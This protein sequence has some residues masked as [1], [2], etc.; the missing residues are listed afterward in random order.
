MHRGYR[1]IRE[2]CKL[3]LK[4]SEEHVPGLF[5]GFVKEIADAGHLV[6]IVGVLHEKK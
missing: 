1:K 5:N 3:K 6:Y 4:T 2:P